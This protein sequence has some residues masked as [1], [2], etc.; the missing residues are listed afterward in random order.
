LNPLNPNIYTLETLKPL[1]RR[2]EPLVPFA[3]GPSELVELAVALRAYVA[4][5]RSTSTPVTS[6]SN[7]I[8]RKW[9]REFAWS[10]KVRRG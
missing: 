7:L 1:K 10:K 8:A 6:W 5:R 4:T 9:P 2:R 3:I